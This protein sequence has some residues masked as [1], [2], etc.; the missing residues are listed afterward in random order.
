MTTNQTGDLK[1]AEFAPGLGMGFGF[2]VVR[3][4]IGTFRYQSIG[5]FAKGGAFRTYAWGDP[6]K[7]LIGIIMFQRTNGGGDMAPEISAFST[8]AYAALDR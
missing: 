2:G 5:T 7:D 8:L 4:A 1:G 6:S 3:D